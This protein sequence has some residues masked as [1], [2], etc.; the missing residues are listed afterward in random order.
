MINLPDWLNI[1]NIFIKLKNSGKIGGIFT[2]MM[3]IFPAGERRCEGI[4][5]KVIQNSRYQ[6][7]CFCASC[8]FLSGEQ[9]ATVTGQIWSGLHT[10]CS[11]NVRPVGSKSQ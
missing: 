4:F 3:S 2:V 11:M 8:F 9:E 10:V 7:L 1:Q 5:F 6:V